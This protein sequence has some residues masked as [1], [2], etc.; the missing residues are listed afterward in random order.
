MASSLISLDWNMAASDDSVSGYVNDVVV[1][2]LSHSPLWRVAKI[3]VSDDEVYFSLKALNIMLIKILQSC[4]PIIV[5][6]PNG[7]SI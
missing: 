2:S 4:L 7:L 3:R 5:K 1:T 6:L